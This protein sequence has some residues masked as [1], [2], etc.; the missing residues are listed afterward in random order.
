M[1]IGLFKD[2]FKVTADLSEVRRTVRLARTEE[3]TRYFRVDLAVVLV[4]CGPEMVASVVWREG[5]SVSLYLCIGSENL[6][7]RSPSVFL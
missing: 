2:Y 3:G 7:L 4:F 6:L 5:G 1:R